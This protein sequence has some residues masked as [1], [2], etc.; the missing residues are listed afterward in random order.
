[1][2]AWARGKK[3]KGGWRRWAYYTRVEAGGIFGMGCIGMDSV[4]R[5]WH[6]CSRANLVALHCSV[7]PGSTA[8][9]DTLLAIDVN[10]VAKVTSWRRDTGGFSL[11]TSSPL[12]PS[13]PRSL[14]EH[15]SCARLPREGAGEVPTS[16]PCRAIINFASEQTTFTMNGRNG[17]HRSQVLQL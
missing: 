13:L 5:T 10:D 9:L 14:I 2:A 4:S 15:T 6:Q 12:L 3:S 1:M 7:S 16:S 8:N 11:P 17:F